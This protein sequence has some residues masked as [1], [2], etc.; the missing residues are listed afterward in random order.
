[1]TRLE[2]IQEQ[3]RQTWDRFAG[4]WTK[5]DDLVLTWLKPAGD[6]IIRTLE[7]GEDGD[8]LDVAAGTGE[9]GLSIAALRP[10]TRVVLT[11]VSAA[12][13]TAA[14]AHAADRGLVNVQLRE[15]GV[16]PLPFADA[17]F[18]TISCRFGLMFFPDVAESIREFVR[19]LRPGGRLSA[20]VW[21]EAAGNPWATIP[22]AAI[23]AAVDLPAP[24]P[25]TPG[26]FRCATPTE[27]ASLFSDAGLR[28][29]RE[30]EIRGTL[31]VASAEDYWTFITEIAAPVVGGL[32]LADDTSRAEIKTTTTDQIRAFEGA[33]GPR[34][35]YHSRCIT[36]AR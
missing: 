18:D 5:W 25:G 6:E 7:L 19:V 12:M 34:I 11:D 17:S 4:G 24:Q 33:S 26:L 1:M 36:G 14:R 35:P 23:S 21:A 31:D 3:Q 13:L 2:E 22:M 32:A 27:I 9:P 29:V 8:H 28:D 16:D 10:R 20:T 15:C 30:T